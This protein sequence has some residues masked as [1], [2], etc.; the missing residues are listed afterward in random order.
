[1]Q[2][3]LAVEMLDPY[4]LQLKEVQPVAR[5]VWHLVRQV[6]S[7]AERSRELLV[8][9]VDLDSQ[10]RVAFEEIVHLREFKL[11]QSLG[12]DLVLKL[13]EIISSVALRKPLVHADNELEVLLRHN[14]L[15]EAA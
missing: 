1:M 15:V 11:F 4:W 5:W 6:Q 14:S 12:S 9:I 2:S 13:A 10:L 7:A 8:S 3:V